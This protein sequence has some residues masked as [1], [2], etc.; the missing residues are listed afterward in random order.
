MHTLFV[1]NCLA[2]AVV[3]QGIG[4]QAGELEGDA[5]RRERGEESSR[6]LIERGQVRCLSPKRGIGRAA[7]S[8]LRAQASFALASIHFRAAR[9]PRRGRIRS[10]SMECPMRRLPLL[11]AI[12]VASFPL[13]S[14]APAQAGTAVRMDIAGLVDRADVVIEA[15]VSSARAV[16]GP[17]KRIDTEYTLIVERTFYGDSAPPPPG[18][19]AE[20]RV[21]RL[22]GGVL[23]DG[24]G[25]VIAGIPAL[26]SGER[27]ILFL[28]RADATGMRMPV[29]LAQGRLRVVTDAAGKRSLV[30]DSAGVALVES[31]TDVAVRGDARTDVAV[32]AGGKAVLDYAATVAE[33][34]ARAAHKRATERR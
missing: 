21:I 24:R 10:V 16:L 29:G 25:M 5:P 27:A 6:V 34:E 4:H 11:A 26:S 20:T 9:P 1:I 15:R 2:R 7:R 8:R 3:M 31:R 12:A 22:P 30:Q 33:I 32:H 19:R 28:T 14:G 13:W 18:D 17:G 23:P